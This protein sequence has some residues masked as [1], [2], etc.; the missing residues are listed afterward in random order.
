MTTPITQAD[1]LSLLLQI[2]HI[3][4]RFWMGPIGND[5]ASMR[6]ANWSWV[7]ENADGDEI[8][9]TI[10]I[11]F[12]KDSHTTNALRRRGRKGR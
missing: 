2:S 4:M 5:S 6:G 12:R 8:H 10:L 9:I 1:L 11:P 3:V 7:H